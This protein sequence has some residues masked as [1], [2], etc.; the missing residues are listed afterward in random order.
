ML[1]D[2]YALS[3]ASQAD[4]ALLGQILAV[5][6]PPSANRPIAVDSDSLSDGRRRAR[7]RLGHASIRPDVFVLRTN[8][9]SVSQP[10]QGPDGDGSDRIPDSVAVGADRICPTMAVTA[11]CRSFSRRR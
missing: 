7:T 10:P 5:L 3:G 4:E 6:K 2:V 9:T 8:T 1:T 11:S